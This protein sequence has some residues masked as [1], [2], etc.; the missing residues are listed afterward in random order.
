MM[1][2]YLLIPFLFCSIV[3]SAQ[4]FE[5]SINY[6][7]GMAQGYEYSNLSSEEDLSFFGEPDLTLLNTIELTLGHSNQSIN[8]R[9][10]YFQ[11]NRFSLGFS[12]GSTSLNDFHGYTYPGPYYGFARRDRKSELSSSQLGSVAWQPSYYL[13][14]HRYLHGELFFQ[15]TLTLGI[16]WR[17]KHYYHIRYASNP[18]ELVVEESSNFETL[19]I[20]AGLTPGFGWKQR[21]EKSRAL[22]YKVGVP[23]SLSNIYWLNSSQSQLFQPNIGLQLAVGLLF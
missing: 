18:E 21:M 8:S 6:T 4:N 20:K 19:G 7:L 22:Y 15:G 11:W 5:V 23:I 1:K 2:N 13:R 9:P 10:R 16:D 14:L 3:L 17:L 12:F